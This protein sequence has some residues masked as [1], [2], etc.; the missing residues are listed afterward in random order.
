MHR[1]PCLR[2]H[3]FL[4]DILIFT[5]LFAFDYVR[6]YLMPHF[7]C[8]LFEFHQC[9]LWLAISLG[10]DIYKSSTAHTNWYND[11]PLFSLC[12]EVI[13]CS[14]FHLFVFFSLSISFHHPRIHAIPARFGVQ[15][16]IRCVEGTYRFPMV[17]NGARFISSKHV[18]NVHSR[19]FSMKYWPAVVFI[20]SKWT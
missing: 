5:A 15:N 13:V 17:A 9:N 11:F 7:A 20:R 6:S 3:S 10:L 2:S 1:S 14:V 19:L 16:N 12:T 18:R 8:V 4:I